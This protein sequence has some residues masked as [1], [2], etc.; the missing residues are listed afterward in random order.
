MPGC[1]LHAANICLRLDAVFPP[2]PPYVLG[3]SSGGRCEIEEPV[4]GICAQIREGLRAH[5]VNN[6][7]PL[8]ESY[9]WQ[10]TI[11]IR[12]KTYEY[13]QSAPTRHQSRC[14]GKSCRKST[15]GDALGCRPVVASTCW[16]ATAGVLSGAV[17]G[18][19]RQSGP[20]QPRAPIRP[21]HR[22]LVPGQQI[23][24][25][26]LQYVILVILPIFLCILFP[27]NPSILLTKQRAPLVVS[28]FIF[29]LALYYA[30]RSNYTSGAHRIHLS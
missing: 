13:I 3:L 1:R 15:V 18:A 28:S 21:D 19:E 23:P 30:P 5:G 14:V 16:R 11:S 6:G 8:A 26:T 29:T 17:S 24:D 22:S 27:H 4:L 10:L 20:P 9:A 12:G 25:P 2:K 7:F